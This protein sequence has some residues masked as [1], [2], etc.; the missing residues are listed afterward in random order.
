M[1]DRVGRRSDCI[2][3]V[4]ADGVAGRSQT[5]SHT[6]RDALTET[7]VRTVRG[8]RFGES[9]AEL[10]ARADR[11]NMVERVIGGGGIVAIRVQLTRHVVL[12][13]E[14]CSRRSARTSEVAADDCDCSH[15]ATGPAWCG[16]RITP[17]PAMPD[18]EMSVTS[19][20]TDAFWT[21][22][23][24][25]RF[26]YLQNSKSQSCAPLIAPMSGSGTSASSCRCGLSSRSTKRQSGRN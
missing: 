13:V 7:A 8:L 16:S 12:I 23:V 6:L 11:D 22:V 17:T 10:R 1:S 9:A 25:W 18:Q 24:D 4:A 14:R 20:V 3:G 26:V 21:D 19:G 5:R 15:L 2:A